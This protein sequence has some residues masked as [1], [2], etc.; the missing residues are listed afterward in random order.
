M[1]NGTGVVAD[2]LLASTK[3]KQKM[4]VQ[5]VGV[6]ENTNLPRVCVYEEDQKCVSDVWAFNNDLLDVLGN[7]NKQPFKFQEVRVYPLINFC[8][9]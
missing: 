4:W 9:F 5:V 2:V 6:D 3:T 1:L 8:I 7:W